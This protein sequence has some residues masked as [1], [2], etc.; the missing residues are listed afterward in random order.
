M[1]SKVV[2]V[3]EPQESH[4]PAAI[5]WLG[6]LRRVSM[7]VSKK[8]GK[9]SGSR[10]QIYYVLYWT[11]DSRG[12]GVTVLRG[13]DRES[14]EEWWS[15]DRSLIKPPP[16]ATE[17][18]VAILGLLWAERSFDSG[19]RAFGLGPMH[20]DECLG[21]MAQTGRLYVANDFS[22]LA[23]PIARYA[24]GGRPPRAHCLASGCEWPAAA[25]IQG[26]SRSDTRFAS[27]AAL[28]RRFERR[29][30]WAVDGPG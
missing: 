3:V 9:S 17:E 21:R 15:I 27:G 13:R 20:G 4:E 6:E 16:F 22:P 26:D 7:A 8:T 28:V 10:N 24:R 18:D 23:V 19:L 12:F 25:G 2:E 14:A 5:S 1:S 29:H 11:T 30:P